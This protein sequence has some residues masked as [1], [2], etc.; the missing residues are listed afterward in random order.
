MASS[1]ADSITLSN[2]MVVTIPRCKEAVTVEM[3]SADSKDVLAKNEVRIEK[4][5]NVWGSSAGAGSDFFDI[6]R[7]H[8][9]TEMDRLQKMDED[10]KDEVES[11]IYQKQREAGFREAQQE[12]KRRATKRKLRKIRRMKNLKMRKAEVETVEGAPQHSQNSSSQEEDEDIM[13]AIKPGGQ[14]KKQMVCAN[15]LFPDHHKKQF[16]IVESNSRIENFSEDM[17]SSETGRLGSINQRLQESPK[18]DIQ[19]AISEVKHDEPKI[20]YVMKQSNLILRESD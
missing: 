10:W 3:D 13:P 2:G 12:H 20:H 8:R 14:D 15:Q 11:K 7:R 1:S 18:G 19:A 4:V 16:E 9:Y 5:S 17:L 6:Y